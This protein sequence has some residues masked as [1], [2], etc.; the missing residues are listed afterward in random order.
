ME[1][2]SKSI[3]KSDWSTGLRRAEE[4]Q[5]TKALQSVVSENE[6]V[7]LVTQLNIV[8]IETMKRDSSYSSRFPEGKYD[9]M[10]ARNEIALLDAKQG[11][12]MWLIG[13]R[14]ELIKR[15]KA[16][17]KWGYDSFEEYISDGTP[18]SRSSAYSYI[19]VFVR[20]NYSDATKHGSKLQ[21]IPAYVTSE[22][23][24]EEVISEITGKSYREAKDILRG[25]PDEPQ[26]KKESE[27]VYVESE[28]EDPDDKTIVVSRTPAGKHEAFLPVFSKIQ[29]KKVTK[30]GEIVFRK[31]EDSQFIKPYNVILSWKEKRESDAFS[32]VM[33][34]MW[35][36]ILRRMAEEINK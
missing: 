28:D 9:P 26:S 15:T 10:V 1:S 4:E 31:K 33:D 36:L 23:N 25:E 32:K 35:P 21:L 19:N 29:P 30:D 11:G 24:V 20:F 13:E 17:R 16:F 18:Y 8:P 22:D 7:N 5:R 2:K 3:D 12:N 34:D 27:A 14:L 6:I